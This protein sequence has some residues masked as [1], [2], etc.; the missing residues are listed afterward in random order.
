MA[1]T[2]SVLQELIEHIESNQ[3]DEGSVF[4]EIT[5]VDGISPE[6]LPVTLLG[7]ECV[8]TRIGYGGGELYDIYVV[9]I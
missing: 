3:G 4:Q 6:G 5:S 9:K 2:N 1:D 7:Q 8:S